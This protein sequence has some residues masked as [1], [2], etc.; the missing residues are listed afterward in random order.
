MTDPDLYHL[1]FFL[2]PPSVGDLEEA[3]EDAEGDDVLNDLIPDNGVLISGDA[4]HAE[5]DE[6]EEPTLPPAMAHQQQLQQEQDLPAV[7]RIPPKAQVSESPFEAPTDIDTPADS[8]EFQEG[9]ANRNIP[10]SLMMRD[11]FS[12]VR[13]TTGH[14][15][16]PRPIEHVGSHSAETHL[17]E[18]GGDRSGAGLYNAALASAAETRRLIDQKKAKRA[19]LN[20]HFDGGLSKTGSKDSG[21]HAMLNKLGQLETKVLQTS[22]GGAPPAPTVGSVSQHSASYQSH[23]VEAREH[24]AQS[25]A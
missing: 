11:F 12:E 19:G 21:K 20:A 2:T 9:V 1:A 25:A 13:V 23:D 4:E 18:P 3:Y 17:A 14:D 5:E 8:T 15:M 16:Q 24:S 7:S 6:V 22:M 10:A